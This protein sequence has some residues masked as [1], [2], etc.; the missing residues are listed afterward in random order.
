MSF[1]CPFPLLTNSLRASTLEGD[2]PR[3]SQAV[4]LIA[5]SFYGVGNGT[6]FSS[7]GRIDYTDN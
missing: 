2:N 3:S 7:L 6:P 5:P 4:D 1:L